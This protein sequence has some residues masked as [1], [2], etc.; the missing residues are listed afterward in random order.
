M[1]SLD[2]TKNRL[3]RGRRFATYSPLVHRI[4][5]EYLV[6]SLDSGVGCNCSGCTIQGATTDACRRAPLLSCSRFI[7]PPPGKDSQALLP[8]SSSGTPEGVHGRSHDRG[9]YVCNVHT[10]HHSVRPQ[11]R[12]VRRSKRALA[13]RDRLVGRPESRDGSIAAKSSQE[14]VHKSATWTQTIEGIGRGPLQS[15]HRTIRRQPIR[16]AQEAD[17][18]VGNRPVLRCSRGSSARMGG[19]LG[20]ITRRITRGYG[21]H[22]IGLQASN[23]DRQIVER[24]SR[25]HRTGGTETT[26]CMVLD[27]TKFT[28]FFILRPPF[29]PSRP[30]RAR[31]PP[32]SQLPRP[33]PSS[34]KP[35]DTP[36]P[37]SP[38]SPGSLPS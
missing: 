6:V 16:Y 24:G 5:G 25:Q 19:L 4:G 13:H 2:G 37:T 18:A 26:W 28:W 14:G 3:P 12:R 11:S 21:M 30:L 32:S 36:G 31:S 34:S 9:S 15:L 7:G 22:P 23:A 29:L 10:T 1:S 27:R 8:S 20:R 38:S 33:R 35:S 17:A